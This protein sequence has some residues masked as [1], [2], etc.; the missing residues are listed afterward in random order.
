MN[1][2]VK[3]TETRITTQDNKQ[4]NKQQKSNDYEKNDF[5]GSCR[6]GDDRKFC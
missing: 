2:C 3:E 6:N 1:C 5:I 4:D